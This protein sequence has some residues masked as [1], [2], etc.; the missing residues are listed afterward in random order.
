MGFTHCLGVDYNENFS[1]VVR[2]QTIKVILILAIGNR[3]P[4]HQLDINNA[5][6]QGTLTEKV[7]MAIE[8][9]L[10]A[11]QVPTFIACLDNTQKINFTP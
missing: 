11:K 9:T 1:L 3:W 4:T 2:P 7:Y 5:F 10:L 6:L 8:T